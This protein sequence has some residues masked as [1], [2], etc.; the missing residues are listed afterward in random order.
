MEMNAGF[1]NSSYGE[2]T[3]YLNEAINRLRELGS[4]AI[5]GEMPKIAVIGNQS[6]GKSSLIEAMSGVNFP[7]VEVQFMEQIRVPRQVGT[8][9]RCPMEVVLSHVDVDDA[10]WRCQITLRLTHDRNGLHL[11]EPETIPFGD[12]M[13]DSNVVEDRLKRAQAAIL[14]LPFSNDQSVEPFLASDYQPP[15]KP[16]LDFS[17]NVVRLDVHGPDLVDVTFI[18]LPGVISNAPEVRISQL[19]F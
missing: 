3:R 17:R 18:D 19:P 16:R 13:T 14:E 6:A 5:L 9:T 2:N 12:V 1:T 7:F 8:C 10:P 15:A 11:G 4:E